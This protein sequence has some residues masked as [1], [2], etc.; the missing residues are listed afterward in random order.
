MGDRPVIKG[1]ASAAGML[2]AGLCQAQPFD[3]VGRSEVLPAVPEDD[4]VFVGRSLVDAVDDRFLGVVGVAGG[5]PA[6]HAFAFSADK[7]LIFTVESFY[8]RGNRGDR[9]DTVTFI[10]ATTL[11]AAGEVVI[12]PKT[13]LMLTREGAIALSDDMRFLAVFNLTPATSLSIVD[14]EHRSFVGEISTPGCSLVYPAGERRYVM[15]CANGGLLTVSLDQEGNEL[16][17]ARTEAFFDARA[18]PVTEAAVRYE[19]QWLFVSFDGIVHPLDI[20]GNEPEVGSTWSLLTSE[21]RAEG[22]R[23]AGRQHLAIHHASSR[24]YSLVRRSEEPLDDPKVMDGQEV[25]VY[26][27]GTQRRIDRWRAR[28]EAEDEAESEGEDEGEGGIGATSGDG[29]SGILVTQGDEPLL[30]S[31]GEGVSV[32]DAMSG[33]YIHER[34]EHAPAGGRLTTY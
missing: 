15:L 7:R 9:T 27:L 32:R 20:S 8:T 13:A 17:K 34:L 30:I 5:G 29:V 33:E 16:S 28:S 18:D 25:W 1:V 22:W 31:V 14:V 23:I 10:D 3:S 4:W 12:P 2:L 26:D 19:D 11:G 21:D 6:G 24:L